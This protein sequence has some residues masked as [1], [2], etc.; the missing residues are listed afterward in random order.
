MK[1]GILATGTI[2]KT[3][4]DTVTHMNIEGEPETLTAVGSRSMDSAL[5]FAAKHGIPR[6]YASYEALVNDPA[7]DAVYI[8]TP[9]SMHYE[10][11]LL[12]L[13]AGK[14]VLCEKPFTT[15]A[16]DAEKLYALANEKN[17][18]IME[19]LWTLF[20]PAYAK[21]RE[22]ISR[23]VI[24]KVRHVRAEYGFIARGAR[25]ARKFDSSLA[26]GALLDVGIY[27]LGFLKTVFGK[28]SE[29]FTTIC[30]IN[31]YGT[32]DLSTVQFRF[33]NGASAQI[34]QS[35]GVDAGRP[36]VIYGEKGKIV[37]PDYQRCEAFSVITWDGKEEF[38]RFPFEA[39]GFEYEI[40]SFT[41]TVDR[42]S[43][44]T[45]SYPPEASLDILRTLDRIRN[46]W[47][48]RFSFED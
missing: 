4:A 18:L 8:A 30:H 43:V 17:L 40:R 13:N 23:G 46:A 48:L 7:V 31:E 37:I 47:D 44:K 42:H 35:I 36:A 24:G 12:C 25:K 39:S 19:G 9:N 1:W 26:G 45:E 38:F 21:I 33:G 27:N 34:M 3:F 20:I 6:A 41:E 10:N 28:L 22:L 2:A 32:D 15:N 5:A 14:H 29:D 16:E 11:A